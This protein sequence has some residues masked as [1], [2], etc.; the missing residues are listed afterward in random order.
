MGLTVGRYFK[1]DGIFTI[2]GG[3]VVF[4]M[5]ILSAFINPWW[6]IFITL[7]TGWLFSQILIRVFKVF[8]QI[9]ALI[10]T[11]IGIVGIIVK[12]V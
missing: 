10:L 6:S 12:L 9:L 8:A 4:G 3:I 11:V 2:V 5:A 7:I 1:N